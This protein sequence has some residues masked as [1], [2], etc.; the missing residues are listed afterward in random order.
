MPGVE[1][2]TSADPPVPLVRRLADDGPTPSTWSPRSPTGSDSPQ[3]PVVVAGDGETVDP[4]AA[5]NDR[6]G[7]FF[8]LGEP[9]LARG[10][11]GGRI[12]TGSAGTV[13]G[14]GRVDLGP[15]VVRERP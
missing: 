3:P 15:F 10:P 7:A 13:V 12:L 11:G 2:G 4:D 6:A 5:Q 8:V 1:G 14:P 9:M